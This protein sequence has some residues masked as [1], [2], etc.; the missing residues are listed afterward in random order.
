MESCGSCLLSIPHHTAAVGVTVE[1]V[2]SAGLKT[3]RLFRRASRWL[4]A[5]SMVQHR[6]M[7]LS[8]AQ[9]CM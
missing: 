7:W 5:W 9:L 1:S 6:S 8:M 3:Y 2:V 4:V